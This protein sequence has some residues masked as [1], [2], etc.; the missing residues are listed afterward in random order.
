MKTFILIALLALTACGREED[1]CPKD[2]EIP[3]FTVEYPTLPTF[4]VEYPGVPTVVV[5]R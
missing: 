1:G 5:N 3:T 4:T 2:T